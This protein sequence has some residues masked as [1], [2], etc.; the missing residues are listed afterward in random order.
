MLYLISNIKCLS[1]D[2]VHTVC[3]TV[4]IC[5]VVKRTQYGHESLQEHGLCCQP[6]CRKSFAHTAAQDSEIAAHVNIVIYL[7]IAALT[8]WAGLP[9]CHFSET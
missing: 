9:S 4:A 8:L 7:K 2:N 5:M 3:R 1:E 6:G